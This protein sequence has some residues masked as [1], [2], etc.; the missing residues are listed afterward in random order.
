VQSI[1]IYNSSEIILQRKESKIYKIFILIVLLF[2]VVL[3]LLITL[4]KYDKI[5]KLKGIVKDNKINL[6]VSENDLKSLNGR[7]II[8]NEKKYKVSIYSISE[9]IYDSNYNAYYEITM[10]IALNN[11]VLVENNI[12]DINILYGK[13]TLYEQVKKRIKEGMHQ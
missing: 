1:D 8:V 4:Y 5:S 9:A 6:T 11:H 13:T 3:L 10:N 12:L 7:D 2:L